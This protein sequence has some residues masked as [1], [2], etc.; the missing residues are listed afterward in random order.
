MP[1]FETLPRFERDWKNLTRQQQAAFRKV[2]TEYFVPDLAAS[3]GI[4]RMA[5]IEELDSIQ[6][7][8][9]PATFGGNGR[10]RD[11]DWRAG[12]RDRREILR[13]IFNIPGG[14]GCVLAWNATRIFT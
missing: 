9:H 11:R 2:I 8:K 13:S 5:P 6:R 7:E 14:R 1:T 3:K 12:L 4:S 10:G